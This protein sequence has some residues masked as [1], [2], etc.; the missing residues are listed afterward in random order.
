MHWA[1][2]RSYSVIAFRHRKLLAIKAYFDDE[3]KL[4][5]QK[6]TTTPFMKIWLATTT[7]FLHVLLWVENRT[8]FYQIWSSIMKRVFWYQQSSQ[9]GS[10]YSQDRNIFQRI[11]CGG[12]RIEISGGGWGWLQITT[13]GGSCWF[14]DEQ[15]V[16]VLLGRDLCELNIFNQILRSN[17]MHYKRNYNQTLKTES[18]AF[19]HVML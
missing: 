16:K 3:K 9:E 12:P 13:V 19:V 17:K 14:Y 10:F 2:T 15:M 8:W 18:H 6:S 5:A 4:S 11:V 1:S 7:S